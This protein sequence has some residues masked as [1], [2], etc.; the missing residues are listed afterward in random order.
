[1]T[2]QRGDAM[3]PT[4]TIR[5]VPAACIGRPIPELMGIPL[6]DADPQDAGDLFGMPRLGPR[7]IRPP[8]GGGTP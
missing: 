2:V 6:R 7:R 8:D 4:R 5:P 3:P 1:M